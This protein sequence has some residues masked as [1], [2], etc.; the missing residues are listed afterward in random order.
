[1]TVLHSDPLS[2]PIQTAK[3][4]KVAQR[5]ALLRAALPNVP[6]DGWTMKTL[7]AAAETAGLERAAAHRLFPGGAKDAIAHFRQL[8]DRLMLEDL[9]RLDLAGM[10]IR[11]RI[12][13]G[14]RLHLERWTPYREAIR[15]ALALSPLP[16]YVGDSLRGGYHTVDAIWRAA[17]DKSTDYNFYTKRGLLAGVYATTLVYWLNDRSEGCT[18]TW[19]FLDRRIQNVME[20]P[21]LQKRIE[22]GLKLLP[23]PRR[24]FNHVR[25]RASGYRRRTPEY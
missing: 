11:E 9:A 12:A 16:P 21:K 18:D 19:K 1:M 22:E 13:T 3:A 15:A 8:A 23:D 7:E 10:K 4:E 24:L 6:F 25:E 2:D 17:G 5:D 14:V 20:I